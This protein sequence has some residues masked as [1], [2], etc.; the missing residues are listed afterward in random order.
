MKGF[1]LAAGLGT[2]LRPLTENTPKCLLRID[3]V[4]LID[5]WLDAFEK[6]GVD[7]VLV[8]LHHLPDLV[9][10]HLDARA[11]PTGTDLLGTDASRQCWDPHS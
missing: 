10:R 11:S 4:P 8:N 5:G 3:G 2:R 7:E 9:C 6:A 1:L